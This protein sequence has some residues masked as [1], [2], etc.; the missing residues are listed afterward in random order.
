MSRS[1]SKRRFRP[2]VHDIG[3]NWSRM[4]QVLAFVEQ[5]RK[6]DLV[7]D[8][9]AEYAENRLEIALCSSNPDLEQH[10]LE[11]MKAW[12]EKMREYNLKDEYPK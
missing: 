3:V 1:T 7:T 11:K 9:L 8:A 2:D 4:L 6:I 5:T 10:L 12:Y